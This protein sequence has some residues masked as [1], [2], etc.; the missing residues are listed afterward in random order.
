MDYKEDVLFQSSGTIS[1]PELEEKYGKLSPGDIFFKMAEHK[2]FEAAK[3][4]F[5]TWE[6]GDVFDMQY[7]LYIAYPF[8]EW[9]DDPIECF[10]ARAF[11]MKLI[12]E[13]NNWSPPEPEIAMSQDDLTLRRLSG[14]LPHIDIA[15]TDFIVD[16]K[17]RELRESA[18]PGNKLDINAMDLSPS[19]DGYLSYYH[20]PDHKRYV[21]EETLTELPQN[22]MLLEIPHELVLDP[23][24]VIQEQGLVTLTLLKTYPV[25]DV[26]K[27]KLIPLNETLLPQVISENLLKKEQQSERGI[28]R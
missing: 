24:A 9:L 28:A 13:Y 3:A 19:E 5:D 15:G 20:L 22:V 10:I 14:V 2:N 6:D 4:E 11:A 27:A 21:P 17:N 1:V 18:N 7:F 16:W 12:R 26:L 23:I 25:Q 8:E